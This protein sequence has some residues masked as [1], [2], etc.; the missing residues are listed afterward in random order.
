MSAGRTCADITLLMG[1]DIALKDVEAALKKTFRLVSPVF[2]VATSG[3]VVFELGGYNEEKL[4][5]DVYIEKHDESGDVSNATRAKW[6]EVGLKAFQKEVATDDDAVL[7]DFL[8]DLLHYCDQNN[9][10]FDL[11]LERARAMHEEE[12]NNEKPPRK[13]KGKKT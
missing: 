2:P 6:A 10:D 7:G 1:P 9:Y 13:K 11:A 3:R 12:V 5:G 8:T 4:P